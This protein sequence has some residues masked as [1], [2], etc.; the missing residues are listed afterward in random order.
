[1][2]PLNAGVRQFRYPPTDTEQTSHQWS[3]LT[4]S[5]HRIKDPASLSREEV[6]AYIRSMLENPDAKEE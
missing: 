2:N 1:M 6:E 5:V 3:F 4:P